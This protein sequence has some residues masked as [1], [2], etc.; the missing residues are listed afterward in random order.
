MNANTCFE[1][2]LIKSKEKLF[3]LNSRGTLAKKQNNI[4]NEK[5][6]LDMLHID[7]GFPETAYFC[8]SR[9][10]DC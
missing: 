9:S 4:N 7:G 6:N 1:K 2:K 5:C 8:V 3:F 10:C